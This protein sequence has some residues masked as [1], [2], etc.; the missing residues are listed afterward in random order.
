[1]ALEALNRVAAF[2][3]VPQQLQHGK[4][5]ALETHVNLLNISYKHWKRYVSLL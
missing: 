3:Q 1:M 2:A 5:C 4:S